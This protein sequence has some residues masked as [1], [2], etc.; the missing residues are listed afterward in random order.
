MSSEAD[1]RYMQ[2]A[3]E[4]ARQGVGL[5][6]PNPCVGAVLVNE[7]RIVGVG[8]HTYEGLKHAEILALEQAGE[9]ARGATLY[10]N[11]EPCCHQGRTGPCADA[12][13][14]AGVSRVVA[15]MPDPNPLVA[16]QGL[17]RLRA[18]GIEVEVGPGAEEAL[19]LNESFAKYIRHKAPL[20]TLKAAMTLDGKIAPPPGE[21]ANPTALGVGGVS[22]GWITSEAARVHV[23][24]LRH[25][26]D[27]ILV[28][29]GTVIADDPLLTDRSGLP[30]RRPLLRVVVD[31]RLR[32]PLHSRVVKTVKDD[33]LVICSFAEEKKRQQLEEH[34]LRVRQVGLGSGNGRPG[35]N[36]ILA[37][38]GELEI[39][40]LLIEGGAMVNWAAL[41]AG[42]VDKVFLYYAPKIL[43]GTGSVPF[44]AGPGFRRM[45]E[46]A[47]LRSFRLHRFGEDFAVE[48]YLK[49]PYAD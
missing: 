9:R 28:G 19:K 31:S 47:Y 29:V 39:T 46:A 21:S 30:R 12:L 48:G 16:G 14:A 23:H 41:A 37:C 4:L 22:G 43:A 34:G 20:V 26:H 8:S 2:K 35:M 17:V 6:S 36:E 49:D 25:Q 7:T 42:V 15:S 27:A 10:L 13:I 32:L 3:L 5:A 11:L 18:A 45:S 40:S 24:Q 38:L 33:V 44:A 1:E